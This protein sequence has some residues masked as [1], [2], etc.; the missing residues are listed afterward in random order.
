MVLCCVDNSI[1]CERCHCWSY[2]CH[3]IVDMTVNMLIWTQWILPYGVNHVMYLWITMFKHTPAFQRHEQSMTH[4][5]L[6][7]CRRRCSTVSPSVQDELSSLISQPGPLWAT[8]IQYCTHNYSASL[9]YIAIVLSCRWQ[10]QTV[11]HSCLH[12]YQ[13]IYGSLSLRWEMSNMLCA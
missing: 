6:L 9:V 13:Q 8:T 1:V 3:V 4:L 5:P 12:P 11:K 10:H 2:H 7:K